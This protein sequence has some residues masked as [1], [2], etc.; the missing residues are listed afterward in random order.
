MKMT[1]SVEYARAIFIFP[2]FPDWNPQNGASTK[3]HLTWA[4]T[5]TLDLSHPLNTNK[6]N[7]IRNAAVAAQENKTRK[8]KMRISKCSG[9]G[10]AKQN[11]IAHLSRRSFLQACSAVSVANR[12]GSH[13]LQWEHFLPHFLKTEKLHERMYV[14]MRVRMY[15]C[16]HVRMY[17]YMHVRLYV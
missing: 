3:A 4:T 11:R 2:A 5:Q 16:M 13:S 17:V 12:A 8:M 7:N 9:N 1:E 10:F 14:S 6:T 15:V